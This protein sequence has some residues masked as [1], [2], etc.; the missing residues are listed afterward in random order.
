MNDPIIIVGA[1]LSG[2]HA[3]SLLTSEGVRCR[4]LEARS[5]IGGRVLSEAAGDGHLKGMFDLGPTWFWPEHEPMIKKL[6]SDLGLP[7]LE[8]HTEGAMLLEQSAHEPIKRHVL[9]EGAVERSVRF[10][11]GVRSLIEAVAGTLPK[12]TIEL[13]TTVTAITMDEN[14]KMLV[15]AEN[16][17]GKESIRANTVILALPPRLAASGI[18]FSPPLPG[19]LIGSLMDKPTWMAGQ[20]KVVAVYDRPFWRDEGLS[21][22]AMSWRGPLQEIHDASPQA[23]YGA[24]FGFFGI[25]AKMRHELGRERTLKLVIEQLTRLFGPAAEQPLTLLYKDWSSDPH[26]AVEK[27]REPLSSFP[28]YGPVAT[29]GLWEKNIVFAGTETSPEQGGHLEGALRS[30]E[31]AAFEVLKSR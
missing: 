26:T 22:G 29:A 31:R 3:A 28:T 9:P 4:V 11:G 1:G 24:L 2:L 27:D 12:G 13:D 23:G 21:G 30:A 17:G 10:V 20:A 15:E 8:Q 14:G 5:R 16:D 18:E 7:T 25:P 19:S 6:V